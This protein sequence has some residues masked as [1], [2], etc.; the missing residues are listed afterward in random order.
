MEFVRKVILVLLFA[1][2]F[3][4]SGCQ[5]TQVVEDPLILL[6]LEPLP[7]NLEL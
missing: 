6:E 4:F 2:L 3:V 7:R 1:S 5:T